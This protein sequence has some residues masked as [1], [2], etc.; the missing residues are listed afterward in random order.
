M[1]NSGNRRRISFRSLIM[2]ISLELTSENTKGLLFLAGLSSCA[3]SS[4]QCENGRC[5]PHATGSA[6]DS[7]QRLKEKGVYSETNLQGLVNLLQEVGRHDLA[8]K[9]EGSMVVLA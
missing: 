4:G 9:C 1:S 5:C 2:D 7:L 6:L 3:P 8:S